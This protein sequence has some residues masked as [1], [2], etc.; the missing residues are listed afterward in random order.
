MINGFTDPDAES[1]AGEGS[2]SLKSSVNNI[3]AY[4]MNAEDKS[5]DGSIYSTFWSSLLLP[6]HHV[7][8]WKKKKLNRRRTFK[9]KKKEQK[10]KPKQEE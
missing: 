8:P 9:V 2:S 1:S 5:V 6:P 10:E 3:V 4:N 7:R